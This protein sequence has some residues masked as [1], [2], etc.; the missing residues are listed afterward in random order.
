MVQVGQYR[1]GKWVGSEQVV[2]VEP[3]VR[4]EFS[5]HYALASKHWANG[6]TEYIPVEQA[7]KEFD[8]LAASGAFGPV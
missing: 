2:S 1:D 4:I 3:K 8:A 5:N 7:M 6:K